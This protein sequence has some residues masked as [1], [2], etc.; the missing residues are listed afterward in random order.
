MN[1]TDAERVYAPPRIDEPAPPPLADEAH[2]YSVSVLKLAIL[3]IASFGFYT[4]YWYYRHWKREAARMRRR[5]RPFG[6]AF[7]YIFFTAPLFERIATTARERGY[8]VPW[9]HGAMAAAVIALT[10]ASRIADRFAARTD[11]VGS[12]DAPGIVLL[13]LM[14]IVLCRVQGTANLV[15]GDPHGELNAR[16]GPGSLV[17]VLL[18]ACVWLFFLLA[19]AEPDWL[20]DALSSSGL[21]DRLGGTS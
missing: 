2:F 3:N 1:T 19:W 14:T 5:I 21:V 11:E 6:R 4:V 12:H 7:F 16:F 10:I 13:F 9:S 15:N 18:G 20:V 8:V 17:V